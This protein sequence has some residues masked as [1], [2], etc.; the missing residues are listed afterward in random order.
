MRM[1]PVAFSI[2]TT[3]PV[4]RATVAAARITAGEGEGAG[5]G[6]VCPKIICIRRRA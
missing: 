1:L 3:Q 6:Q 2:S 5:I 4:S